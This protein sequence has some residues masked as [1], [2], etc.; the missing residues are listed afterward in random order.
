MTCRVELSGQSSRHLKRLDREQRQRIERF[1]LK[2]LAAD[3]TPR[4]EG[5]SLQGTMTGLWGYRTGDSRL[6]C[7]I[8]DARSVVLPLAMENRR[9]VYRNH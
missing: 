6:L 5:G 1:T 7:R 2:R 4:R 8:E 3:A 9:D